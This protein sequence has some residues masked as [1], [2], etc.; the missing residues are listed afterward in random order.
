M[1]R[2]AEDYLRQLRDGVAGRTLNDAQRRERIENVAQFVRVTRLSTPS[3]AH[4]PKASATLSESDAPLGSAPAP[5]GV[6]VEAGTFTDL[7]LACKSATSFVQTSVIGILTSSTQAT[8]N[9]GGRTYGPSS[10]I[11]TCL[12]GFCISQVD[13][14]PI[15]DCRVNPASGTATGNAV[16][17]IRFLGINVTGSTHTSY[18]QDECTPVGPITV[19]LAADISVGASTQAL[20]SCLTYPQWSST[21]PAVATVSTLGVVTG[22][23]SGSADISATCGSNR[24]S[25]TIKV[26]L[27]EEVQT[28]NPNGGS[29]CDDPMTPAVESCDDATAQHRDPYSVTYTRPGYYGEADDSWFTSPEY[30]DYTVVCDVT[31]WYEWNSDLTAAH[32]VDTVVN[33]CWLEPY[34]GNHHH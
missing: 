33:S 23:A 28:Q 21:A 27:A 10:G 2:L 22:V 26:H 29:T 34:N 18:D 24:G 31:D 16:W 7:C 4:P 19:T 8:I 15:V 32:Y 1:S 20:S 30:A 11:V 17:M 3:D 13:L 12:T 25:A 6:F 5:I 14:S 9:T